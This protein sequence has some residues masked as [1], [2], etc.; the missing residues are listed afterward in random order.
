MPQARPSRLAAILATPSRWL[1]LPGFL[2]A[3]YAL[4]MKR[5][6]GLFRPAFVVD[7]EGVGLMR[8][9]PWDFI[10]ARIFFFGAWEPAVSRFM[11]ET[12]RPGMVVADIGAN[13]GY[14]TLLRARAVGPEGH[15]FAVEPSPEIRARLEQAL[16][17]N[18]LGNV[19][20]IP[21]GISDRAERRSF[22]L[23]QANMGAS[24]FG[25]A[26]A[27]GGI[28]LRRLADVVPADMLARLSFIKIDVEGMEVAVM[29]DIA[30]IMPQ[31]PQALTLCAEL[32]MDEA[33]QAIV[34]DFQDAGMECLLLP[35]LY[36]MFDYPSH[37]L[38][39]QAVDEPGPGQLDV[40]LVRH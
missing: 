39:P 11:R 32:R 16:A 7:V 2:R 18:G 15:V 26:V 31:L 6:F 24:R 27:E 20:V 10:D 35:N 37:P 23:S 25:E 3:G 29:R 34:R 40:A 4:A 38:A 17:L 21:Y 14:Y 33:M 30:R 12:I 22:H 36:T 1:F 5:L 28:E 13:I 8:L 19:T 9:E